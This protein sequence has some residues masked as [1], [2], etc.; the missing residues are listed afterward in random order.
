MT[1]RDE[2]LAHLLTRLDD[3]R[4]GGRAPDVSGLANQHPDLADELRQLWAVA[5]VAQTFA[6]AARPRRDSPGPLG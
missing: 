5:Q 3:E 6:K 1:D 4:R 2:R